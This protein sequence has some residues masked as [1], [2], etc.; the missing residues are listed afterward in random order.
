MNRIDGDKVRE[1]WSY[2]G[3]VWTDAEGR[4]VVSLPSFVRLHRDGL[5]CSFD[6]SGSS[7]SDGTIATYA[8]DFGDG[9]NGVGKIATHTHG[10]ASSYTVTLTVT[11]DAGATG[12]TSKAWRP[13]TVDGDARPVPVLVCSRRA[14]VRQR[15]ANV[16]RHLPAWG[17]GNLE[18]R[19]R[20]IAI[21]HAR[22]A[23]AR[24][25][26][27]MM[28]P[29]RRPPSP[30]R[31]SRRARLAERSYGGRPVNG[32]GVS[33][34]AVWGVWVGGGSASAVVDVC[35]ATHMRGLVPHD[36]CAR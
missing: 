11:D 7:D 29:D 21:C 18:Q 3:E 20:G 8:W 10:R 30:S 24:G 34:P 5:T 15:R 32:A 12:S 23:S 9:T 2:S 26:S 33:R 28:P 27:N 14:R 1:G 13:D 16:R 17:R 19:S 36:R 4:A 25:G 31:T 6:G 35:V 22:R